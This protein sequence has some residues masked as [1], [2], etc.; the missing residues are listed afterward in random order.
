[1]MLLHAV[2]QRL[3]ADA[4]RTGLAVERFENS[5]TRVS[6]EL[7][8]RRSGRLVIESADMLIVADGINSAIR[9][10]LHPHEGPPSGMA[11]IWGYCWKIDHRTWSFGHSSS[12]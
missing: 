1:M 9:A 12:Y 3:G 5:D 11:S 2:R 6:V 4:V 10:Q 8:D 7:R